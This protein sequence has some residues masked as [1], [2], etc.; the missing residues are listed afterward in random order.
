MVGLLNPF[1]L[2]FCNVIN[3]FF[4]TLINE[5]KKRAHDIPEAILLLFYLVPGALINIE[6]RSL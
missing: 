6:P 2:R 5:K 4:L 3:M 1:K